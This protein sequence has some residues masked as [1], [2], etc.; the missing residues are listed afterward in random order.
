MADRLVLEQVLG[1]YLGSLNS[2]GTV[3]R[4]FSKIEMSEVKRRGAQF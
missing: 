1:F 4:W 3:E 2:T